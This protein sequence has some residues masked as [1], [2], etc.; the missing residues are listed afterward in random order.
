MNETVPAPGPSVRDVIDNVSVQILEYGRGWILDPATLDRANSLGLEGTFGFW[1]NG[2]AG[3]LGDVDSDVAASAI[4][5]MHPDRVRHF[6]DGRPADMSPIDAT[7]LYCDAAAEWGRERL[8]DIRS[9]HLDRLHQLNNQ[10]AAAA[11]PS[12]G[13]LFAG[14]RS[15]APPTDPA[16]AV[17][18]S[19]NVI[20]EL[21]GGAHLHA[22]HAVGLGPDGAIASAPDPVRGGS[23]GLDRFGWPTP[24]PEA[25][26]QRRAD[27]EDLT[28]FMVEPA[29]AALA[30]AERA[31]Y[32]E[33]VAEAREAMGN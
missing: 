29:F 31:E 17:T 23:S 13:V 25:D 12:V 27:A 22:V 30:T 19:L 7:Y 10:I 26:H 11:V 2:R 18:I 21:R 20:R 5:F 9:D 32:I 33:L 6:W 1:V 16:G 3:V 15:L 28:S 14:W 8:A 24:H 4:G